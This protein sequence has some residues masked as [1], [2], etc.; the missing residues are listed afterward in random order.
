[1]LPASEAGHFVEL[2]LLYLQNCS[3]TAGI[4]WSQWGPYHDSNPA[5]LWM[6]IGVNK[7]E[8]NGRSKLRK[9]IKL[10]GPLF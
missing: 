4:T 7:M 5:C 1:M 10:V 2:L 3:L 9:L 6:G 8:S